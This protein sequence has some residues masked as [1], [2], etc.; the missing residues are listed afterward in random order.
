MKTK[1]LLPILVIVASCGQEPP[2]TT[3]STTTANQLAPSPVVP[4]GTYLAGIYATSEAEGIQL[5]T[6]LMPARR[7]PGKPKQA[8]GQTKVSC[9]TST[10]RTPSIWQPWL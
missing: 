10:P 7:L 2:T 5:K 9:C 6:C 4:N 1:F 8:P 3:T